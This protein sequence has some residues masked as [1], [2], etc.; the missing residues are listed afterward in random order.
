MLLS[1]IVT[2]QMSEK[3]KDI[4]ESGEDIVFKHI[5]KLD[6]GSVK[7]VFYSASRISSDFMI[8]DIDVFPER[9]IVSSLQSFRIS[10]PN[11]S[12][13]IIAPE[14]KPGDE[15]IYIVGLGIYDI[16]AEEKDADWNGIINDVLLSTP[17]TYS[18]A[19]RW[20]TG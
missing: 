7:D 13:I 19:A 17:A 20:H 6:S 2:K 15:I 3:I 16:A 10:R 12:V 5:G 8:V 1:I 4:L 9:E 11:T 14:R 18:Q